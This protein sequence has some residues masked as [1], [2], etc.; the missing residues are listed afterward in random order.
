MQYRGRWLVV[1]PPGVNT[2]TYSWS[3]DLKN[4]IYKIKG[5]RIYGGDRSII[6]KM[7]SEVHLLVMLPTAKMSPKFYKLIWGDTIIRI[8]QILDS[9]IAKAPWDFMTIEMKIHSEKTNMTH[10]EF[11]FHGF[12]KHLF[13]KKSRRDLP[14][15]S[16]QKK[17]VLPSGGWPCFFSF[18]QTRDSRNTPAKLDI[19]RQTA[20]PPAR[21]L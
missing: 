13:K 20:A 19:Q 21:W 18:T 7:A 12:A 3:P 14:L 16:R 17:S 15:F 8:I 10:D 1:H 4:H 9:W 11:P 2:G 6:P 5:L